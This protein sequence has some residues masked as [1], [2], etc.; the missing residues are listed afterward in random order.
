MKYKAN[1]VLALFMGTTAYAMDYFD[2]AV[3]HASPKKKTNSDIISECVLQHVPP[4]YR[5]KYS[6]CPESYKAFK[7]NNILYM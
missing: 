5:D 3:E 4:Q 7:A 1:L 2:K 6:K